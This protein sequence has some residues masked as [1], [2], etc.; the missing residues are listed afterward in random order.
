MG[1]G[2][3]VRKKETVKEALDRLGAEWYAY[4]TDGNQSMQKKVQ[5]EIF[6]VILNGK[7]LFG[8]NTGELSGLDE[9]ADAVS[10]FYLRD[11]KS[12][13][14]MYNGEIQSFFAF[15]KSRIGL[16]KIDCYN[17]DNGTAAYKR[18]E[19]GETVKAKRQKISL[20]SSEERYEESG[21]GGREW[22]EINEANPFKDPEQKMLQDEKICELTM[23]FTKITDCL[24]GRQNNETKK[25]YFKLFAT[26]SITGAIRLSADNFLLEVHRRDILSALKEKFLDYY[27]AER[28]R[29]IDQIQKCPMKKRCEV[30]EESQ[31]DSEVSIPFS[32]K[33]YITYLKR[34]EGKKAGDSAVSMQKKSFEELMKELYDHKD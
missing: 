32:N 5:E 23:L 24:T 8:S 9:F 29:S 7:E 1:S 30:E 31:S 17:Q 25:S 19:N 13:Q 16:R 10:E 22:S 4:Y 26:E 33:L 28:C 34:M 21:E 2:K 27:M 6:T 14:P 3:T 12:F 20:E 15:A 18:E 11:M